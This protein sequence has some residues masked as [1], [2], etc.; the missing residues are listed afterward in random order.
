MG[1]SKELMEEE[2][3]VRQT[4]AWYPSNAIRRGSTGTVRPCCE[5]MISSGTPLLK[6]DS[7][8]GHIIHFYSHKPCG[9]INNSHITSL[10]LRADTSD[11]CELG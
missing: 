4:V 6:K 2:Q 8:H 11:T 9:N 10:N 7:Y 3:R 5:R 1:S